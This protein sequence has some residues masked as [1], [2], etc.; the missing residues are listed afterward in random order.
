MKIYLDNCCFNRPYDEPSHETII[1]ET[2]AKISIQKIIK[3][4]KIDLIWSF[5]LEFENNENPY[6]DQYLA[7][8]DWKNIAGRIISPSEIIRDRAKTFIKTGIKPKDSLHISCAIEGKADYL[9]TTDQKLIKKCG[10]MTEIK[11]LNPIDLIYI[12]EMEGIL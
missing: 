6:E 9:V 4:G 3:E 12:I 10:H 1:L 5:I 11:I 2:H 8:L 7:I